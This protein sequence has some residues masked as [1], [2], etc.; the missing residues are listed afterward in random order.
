MKTAFCI[1]LTMTSLAISAQKTISVDGPTVKGEVHS[2]DLTQVDWQQMNDMMRAAEGK[3]RNYNT[4]TPD[5][6]M[7][8]RWIDRIHNL[9]DYLVQFYNRYG[10]AVQKVLDGGEN[11]LSDPTLGLYIEDLGN[12]NT[13]VTTFSGTIDFT[14]PTDATYE[15]IDQIT[16][17][18]IDN[19]CNKN[20][21]EADCFMSYL[22]LCLTYDYPEAFWLDSYF[23]WQ[24]LWNYRY[25]YD[26]S[27]GKGWVT[28][29]QTIYFTLKDTDFDYR[30]TEFNTQE[31]V[32]NGVEEYKQRIDNIVQNCPAGSRYDK[33]VYFND[34]LTKHNSYNT[35]YGHS[36]NVPTIAWSPMSAL[37]GTTGTIGPV[38]EGYA[39]A[40]KVLCDQTGIPCILAV[41]NA[42]DFALSPGESHMWN[43]VEM[44]NGSWY[45]VDC[46]W[47]DPIDQLNRKQSGQ[48]NHNWLLLGKDDIVGGGG[49]TFAQSHPT[50]IT[51]DTNPTYESQWDY[52]V[53]SF[54]ANQHYDVASSINDITTNSVISSPA[55]DAGGR[56]IGTIETLPVSQKNQLL[57]VGGRKVLIP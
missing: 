18:L 37:R 4:S 38:C 13:V 10:T 22:I 32:T 16:Y 50:S 48:E 27:A 28:Y 31:K 39:R 40:F 56:Y 34:W 15:Q 42:K 35:L 30:R 19:Q 5:L 8:H 24:H 2:V 45:A 3:R 25:N 49:F 57:I 36:N 46:T 53:I 12:Y 29:T 20:W 23:R 51:W 17:N 11:Y 41:G 47:N 33:I 7:S 43:E 52:S 6:T 54:I 21:N 9:P 44:E 55:Y 14:F 26:T 1:L